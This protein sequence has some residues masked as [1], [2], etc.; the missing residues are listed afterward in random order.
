MIVGAEVVIIVVSVRVT[1]QLLV[2]IPFS[3]TLTI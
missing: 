3:L 1:F 2:Q